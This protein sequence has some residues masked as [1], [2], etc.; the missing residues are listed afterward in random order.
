MLIE[1]NVGELAGVST[2]RADVASGTTE[3]AYDPAVVDV[4]TILGAIR[5]SGYG[6]EVAA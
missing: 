4:E 5:A 3:V 2:V 6:A 1:M